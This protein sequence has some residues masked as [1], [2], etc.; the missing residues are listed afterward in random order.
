[1][2]AHVSHTVPD[3]VA[4]DEIHAAALRNLPADVAAYLEGGAGAESTLRAN[5]EAFGNRRQQPASRDGRYPSCKPCGN[6]RHH[7]VNQAYLSLP[8]R[9]ALVARDGP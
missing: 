5:R 2:I 1:M 8:G 9:Q 3:Y 6:S 4:T 7:R